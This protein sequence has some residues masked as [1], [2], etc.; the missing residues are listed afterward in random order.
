[1]DSTS[2]VI[3]Y[4]VGSAGQRAHCYAEFAPLTHAHV[5]CEKTPSVLWEECWQ[6]SLRPHC[7][8][9]L[10][11]HGWQATCDWNS[12]TRHDAHCWQDVYV[13]VIDIGNYQ[14]AAKLGR[15]TRSNNRLTETQNCPTLMFLL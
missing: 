2:T 1:M 7:T 4:S 11:R 15:A 10:L 3:I 12:S 5:K 13:W 8:Q 14:N 9:W 6:S